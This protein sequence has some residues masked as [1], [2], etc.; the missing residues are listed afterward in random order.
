MP[1]SRVQLIPGGA[2]ISRLSAGMMRLPRW[3]LDRHGL[4][5]WLHACLD[6]GITT[7][8]QA[9]I[10]GGYTCEG[11]L[12]EAL[13]LEP[14]LRERMELVTKCGIR[15]VSPNRPAHALKSYDT[16]RAHLLET[17]DNSLRQMRTDRL[18]LLLIHRPDP[19][20]DADETAEALTRLRESGKVRQLGVS[21]F[22]PGQFD[23]LADRLNFPLVVNQIEASV[24]EL[25][26]FQDGTLD[27]CQR[28]RVVPMAWSPLGGKRLFQEY[29]PRAERLR[30]V[31]AEI[32]QELHGAT[33]DQVALAWLLRHPA[34][35]APVLGTGNLD[36][37]RSAAEAENITL[38][39][40]QWFAIWSASTGA[41]VP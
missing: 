34:R 17:V 2:C 30:Q 4:A 18:D 32:G 12:G 31:L 10:Y 25:K 27:H 5:R 15:L 41:P 22:S 6:L 26:A 24:M 3:G 19:L 39:R 28:L 20:L 7:F 13:T 21:N 29:T 36:R 11:L 38:S 16:G 37:L 33:P 9:D 40:E 23:L 1:V 14:A 35:L 8:D